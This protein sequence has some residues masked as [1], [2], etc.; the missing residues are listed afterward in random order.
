M[1][2][3]VAVARGGNPGPAVAVV[4]ASRNRPVRLRWLLN[5][6]GEQTFAAEQFEVLVAHDSCSPEVD[7]LLT[8]HRLRS[9]GQLRHLSLAAGSVVT[10]ASR[11]AAWRVS[12]APFVL[13][14]DDDCRPSADWV[15]RAAAAA[16]DHPGAII[17]GATIPD[18][19]EAA[20]LEGAPWV[21][22]VCVRPPTAWA[23]TCNIG[24]P[25]EMLERLGGFDEQLRVAED[26]DLA[27]RARA[28]GARIVAAPEMLVYHAVE[29]RCLPDMLRSLGRWRDLAWLAKRHPGIRRH[30]WGGIWWKPEH[31][32]LMAALT[33]VGLAYRER[34]VNA[35]A[36]PWLA[37]SLRHR[38]YRPRGIARSIAELPGR[39]AI[40]AAEIVTL[41]RGSIRYRTLLL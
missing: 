21:H 32:A 5:A 34:R 41:G 18:P 39:A 1:A 17:Q 10:G 16:Q 38:G 33:G 20:T 13:F 12:R 6:L 29:E 15:Q 37:L 7:R 4:I 40:D 25:R 24:Y 11:N 31:A 8:T 9:S 3:S 27:I 30:M 19:Q 22:T 28:V 2:Q 14:T 23:E 26:T 36:L 35:L